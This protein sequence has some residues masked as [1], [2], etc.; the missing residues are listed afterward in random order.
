MRLLVACYNV[1]SF[2]AGVE[3]AVHALGR[4]KP[5]LVMVQ[6]CGPRRTLRRFAQFLE[7]EAISSHR[8]FTRVRNAV[9][10]RPPWRL[11][12]VDVHDLPREGRTLRRGFIAAHLRA[13]GTPITAV[14]A[15]LGLAPRERERHA[16][17]LT[18]HLGGVR[19]PLM[20]GADLNEGPDGPAV[21]WIGE[22]LFD[23]GA[24]AGVGARETFPARG[25]TARIDYVFVN[26]AVSVI[27]CWVASTQAA[28]EASD[29]RPL[30]AEVEIQDREAPNDA[31][32]RY[33]A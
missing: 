12:G 25:P 15:H 16:R 4:E 10:F 7:M 33:R 18:D 11:S 3:R 28:V 1:Q 2:R 8:L 9:L 20:L 30:L 22:R 29:H 17:D 24:Q 26:Q 27:R 13:H 19:G 14:S 32:S 6:E 5:D 23:A 31:I 21:R